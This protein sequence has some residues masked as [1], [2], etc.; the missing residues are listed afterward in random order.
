[1]QNLFF[2]FLFSLVV[3]FVLCLSFRDFHK[4]SVIYNIIFR[5]EIIGLLLFQVISMMTLKRS[6]DAEIIQYVKAQVT[7]RTR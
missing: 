3:L 1:M 7:C 4:Y 5:M 6:C 2:F